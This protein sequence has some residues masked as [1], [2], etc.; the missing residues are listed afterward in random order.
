MT[1]AERQAAWILIIDD[2]EA[3]V[4]VLQQMLRSSGYREVTSVTDSRLAQQVFDEVQPDLVL[5]DLHMPHVDGLELL[6]RLGSRVPP[7]GYLPILVLTA[8]T[9]PEPKQA[10]LSRGAKDFLTKP[11]DAQEVLLRI[12][13]LL[14]TRFLHLQLQGHNKAL[15][16]QVRMRTRELE[17]ARNEVLTR[18]A[19]AAEYRDDATGG[20]IQRVG[21]LAGAVASALGL[22]ESEVELI[23]R[24]APLHDVGKIGVP[25]RILL[26]PGRLT[27]ASSTRSRSTQPSAPRSFQAISSRSF[28]WPSR[29]HSP[30]TSGGTGQGT[31]TGS[32]GTRFRAPG[33]SWPLLMSSTR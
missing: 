7:G 24:T 16:T 13:N 32:L 30:I 5:L 17:E 25:D 6:E 26:K 19:I 4:L 2:Q 11:F 21:Q 14:E 28:G 8:D 1:D 29:L 12:R 18:L 20:H 10:C 3:N 33:G 15:E 31:R 23:A 27:P 22:P 9:T